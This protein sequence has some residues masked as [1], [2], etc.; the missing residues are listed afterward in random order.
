MLN[1][2]IYVVI[3]HAYDDCNKQCCISAL[4]FTKQ[5]WVNSESSVPS[6]DENQ[7]QTK[8]ALTTG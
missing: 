4:V 6:H 8:I 1:I 7:I 5:L 3:L 2:G